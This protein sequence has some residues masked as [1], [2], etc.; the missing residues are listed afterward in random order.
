MWI[1]PSPAAGPVEKRPFSPTSP[2]SGKPLPKP[3]R[4]VFPVIHTLY[5][6]D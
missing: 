6:Y 4:G 3:L 1:D 2:H 5:D